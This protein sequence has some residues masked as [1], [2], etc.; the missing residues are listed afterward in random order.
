MSEAILRTLNMAAATA[1]LGVLFGG[2]V[3]LGVWL[4]MK[5]MRWTVNVTMN[6]GK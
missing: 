3:T 4:A 1:G 6:R 2:G 5:S